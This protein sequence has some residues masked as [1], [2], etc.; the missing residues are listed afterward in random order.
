VALIRLAWGL[1]LLALALV[2]ATATLAVLNIGSIDSLYDANAIEIVVPI[3]WAILG[4]LIAA[5]Q[6]RNAMGWLLLATALGIA[7]SG[8]AI[9]YS[10][11]T[12]VTAQAAPFSPWIPW[13]GTVCSTLVYPA[14]LGSLTML[15]LPNGHL[16]SRRWR[17]VIWAG[18]AMTAGLIAIGVLDPE[19]ISVTGLPPIQSPTGIDA[20]A[21]I[22][23]GAV[24]SIGFSLGL[25]IV[26]AAGACIVMRLRRAEGEQRLQ[27][28]WIAYAVAFAVTINIVYTVVALL[29]LPQETVIALSPI[30]VV[31]GFG[32]AIP[33]G[34]AVAILRYRLYDLDLLL[35]RTILYGAV[36]AIL[37]VALGVANLAAQGAVEALFGQPSAVVTAALGIGAG[38][39]FPP[40]R[41]WL[42]PMVDR[43][44][45]ARSRLTLLFTD[46]VG[47]T[48]AI[49]DLGDERWREVLA[50]Y[51]ALVRRELAQHRG[52]EVN[53]AGDG[54]F[55]VF[56]RPMRAV[57]CAVAMRAGV[58][59]LGLR[60]RT[61]L[62]YGEVEMRGEQVTGLAVHA[63]ARVMAEAGAD[64]LLL[65]EAMA[66]AL[67]DSV[68]LREAGTHELRGVPGEWRLFEL[69]TLGR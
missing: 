41:R 44:L 1:C 27:L 56:D 47:S 29:F 37:L 59:V 52:R 11:F 31:V 24:G 33:A 64:Q 36:S 60:V 18:I 16:L 14:G 38:L 62:H 51:R 46:I 54:F 9:Q 12:L 4:A 30:V 5:R 65:S 19:L 15:F 42:R 8:V 21:G 61:G 3:G 32:L 25:T 63:A 58:K 43:A 49:V 40:V 20:L 39:A 48:Q 57:A 28:R 2:A 69:A 50:L 23:A 34:M 66:Q 13:F 55:A 6:P 17:I 22:N 10:R 7:I 26:A 35:N 67:G 68:P 45:P 53:T